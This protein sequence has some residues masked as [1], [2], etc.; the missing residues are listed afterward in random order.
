MKLQLKNVYDYRINILVR[1]SYC[2]SSFTFLPVWNDNNLES[3]AIWYI[4]GPG[5]QMPIFPLAGV[6]AIDTDRWTWH[7][8]V[9][10]K[11]STMS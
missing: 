6:R 7:R 2:I 1:F 8:I 4:F 10:D 11:T 5:S 9:F 3:H